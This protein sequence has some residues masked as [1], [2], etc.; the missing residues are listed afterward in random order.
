MYT[1]ILDFAAAA[2]FCVIDGNFLIDP[3]QEEETKANAYGTIVM[4][5]NLKILHSAIEAHQ[6]LVDIATV[7]RN[8]RRCVDQRIR[9]IKASS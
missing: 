5:S 9:A 8:C 2:S 4:D 3:T 7:V 1:A 6:G